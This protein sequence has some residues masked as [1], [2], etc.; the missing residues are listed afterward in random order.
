M[1]FGHIFIIFLI[2]DADTGYTAVLCMVYVQDI[3]CHAVHQS[4]LLVMG[5]LFQCQVTC[6]RLLYDFLV[7]H[8]K[9]QQ[10]RLVVYL[11][12]IE[13]IS[14]QCPDIIVIERVDILPALF[15]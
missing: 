11:E 2:V 12:E 1:R 4:D 3:L 8:I 13:T 5:L 15:G 10:E 14:F 6:F 9:R 7:S